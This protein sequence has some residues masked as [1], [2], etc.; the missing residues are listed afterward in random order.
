MKKHSLFLYIL[1][2]ITCL[3][4]FT[5]TDVNAYGNEKSVNDTNPTAYS[6]T[7]AIEYAEKYCNRRNNQYYGYGQ[8]CANFVS[9]CLHSGG[10]PI[11]SSW[12]S[13]KMDDCFFYCGDATITW[14]RAPE[15]YAYY[16][17]SEYHY[18]NFSIKS[19]SDIKDAIKEGVKAGDVIYFDNDTDGTVDHAAIIS[20]VDSGMIYYCAHTFSRFNQPLS[21]YF[22]T[23]NTGRIYI[24]MLKD[25]V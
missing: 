5:T 16:E 17:K 19:I 22:Q 13:Y 11:N 2:L 8:D 1:L 14:S 24:V 6:R 15:Q 4:F 7:K 23:G 21:H 12:Y 9:Q 10:I 25:N 20:K 18:K 3:W